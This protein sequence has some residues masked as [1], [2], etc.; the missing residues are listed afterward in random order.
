MMVGAKRLRFV[1]LWLLLLA[2]APRDA[3]VAAEPDDT[4]TVNE[5]NDP[6]DTEAHKESVWS[7]VREWVADQERGDFDAYAAKYADRFHGIRRSGGRVVRFDRA[8][9]MADRKRMF[10]NKIAIAIDEPSVLRATRPSRVYF[11]AQFQQSWHS[12]VY[13]DRGPKILVLSE[14]GDRFHIVREELLESHKLDVLS[15]L[16]PAFAFSVER[17]PYL[18]LGQ[19]AQ[20]SW[21]KGRVFE[22]WDRHRSS[23]QLSWRAVDE[24]ALPRAVKAWIGTDVLIVDRDGATC[25][26]KVGGLRFGELRW[27]FLL[28]HK[29]GKGGP[30]PSTDEVKA[31]TP[32]EIAAQQFENRVLVG[33]L[34]ARA[35]GCPHPIWV[36]RAD[37]PV[38]R[39]FT[40]VDASPALWTRVMD[41]VR[42]LKEYRDEERTF[43]QEVPDTTE[44]R[45]EFYDHARPTVRVIHLDGH[46]VIVTMIAAS[47]SEKPGGG[48]GGYGGSLA[49]IW[50]GT[51]DGDTL[52][53]GKR[54]DSGGYLPGQPVQAVDVDGDGRLELI[55]SNWIGFAIKGVFDRWESFPEPFICPC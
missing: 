10:R 50:H 3:V 47:G 16:L 43:R 18:I 51:L 5:N 20:P 6:E 11:A 4:S 32:D 13:A 41:Q 36:R 37:L 2:V 44:K 33:T 30:T 38:P 31:T 21:L 23:Y 46:N 34:E 53:L 28:D 24:T 52:M 9:W 45:W 49:R 48:C 17:L 19:V 42:L 40:A 35:T 25:A 7:F 12:G 54:L 26:A 22:E 27:E 1:F 8:G 29:T 15:P 39:I 14:A 55:G